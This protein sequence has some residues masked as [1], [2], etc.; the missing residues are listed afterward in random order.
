MV[1][2]HQGAARAVDQPHQSPTGPLLDADVD[3]LRRRSSACTPGS[4][5]TTRSVLEVYSSR[6]ARECQIETAGAIATQ[7]E[8]RRAPRPSG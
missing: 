2:G 4:D 5:C 8:T 6:T 1:I 3:M 7:V